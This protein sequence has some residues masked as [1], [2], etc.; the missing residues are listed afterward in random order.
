MR[1]RHSSLRRRLQSSTGTRSAPTTERLKSLS[2]S[3]LT[4]TAKLVPSSL[5]LR[6][7]FMSAVQ[8]SALNEY[9]AKVTNASHVSV[10]KFRTQPVFLYVCLGVASSGSGANTVGDATTSPG[11][12]PLLSHGTSH[13][14]RSTW[15][16]MT[17]M[18]A[19]QASTSWLRVS[20][21]VS[22]MYS[23]SRRFR[24]RIHRSSPIPSRI[25][26]AKPACL[27]ASGPSQ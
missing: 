22:T 23:P 14:N 15:G 3:G 19:L 27:P 17:R 9:G 26:L 5:A 12:E 16:R 8:A 6:T 18:A 25:E 24:N 2:R 1:R 20:A 13:W 7:N 10:S 11:H 4:L 21:D